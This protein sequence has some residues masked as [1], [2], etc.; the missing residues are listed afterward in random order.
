MKDFMEQQLRLARWYFLILVLNGGGG[1]VA[2]KIIT[3]YILCKYV[4]LKI[5]M[6]A[7]NLLLGQNIICSLHL[8]NVLIEA[9]GTQGGQHPPLLPP[10]R[11]RVPTQLRGKIF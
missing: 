4:Y 5:K 8:Q 1:G 10:E 9:L 11:Q 6:K 7:L 2:V 3:L